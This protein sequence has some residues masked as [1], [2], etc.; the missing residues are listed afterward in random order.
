MKTR[1]Q[2]LGLVSV[3]AI[4]LFVLQNAFAQT[5]DEMVEACL[6]TGNVYICAEGGA[7]DYS[8]C[9][10]NRIEIPRS[11]CNTAPANTEPTPGQE[12][13]GPKGSSISE[14]ITKCGQKDP[15]LEDCGDVTVFIR[16]AFQI[17]NYVFGIIGGIALLFFIYG[18]FT[19]ILSQGNS[20]K[21]QHGKDIIFSAILGI[22]IAFS[23]YALIGFVG[24]MIGIEKEYKLFSAT[25]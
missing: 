1:I 13:T 11:Q 10:G 6:G 22:V 4:S 14:L 12:Q 9:E 19:F 16:L 24:D 15:N 3:I 21:V 8:R 18:G 23:G 2:R 7:L 20:D 25:K 5:N 17:I